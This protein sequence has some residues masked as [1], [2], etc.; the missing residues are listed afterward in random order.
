M[1]Q[2]YFNLVRKGFQPS[3]LDARDYITE[4]GKS[5]DFAYISRPFTEIADEDITI[6]D[7]DLKEYLRKNRET[8]RQDASRT[9]QYVVFEVEPSESDVESAR[10]WSSQTKVE[11]G[12]V[13]GDEIPRYVNG[14]SD[15]PYDARYYTGD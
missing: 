6:T 12:R 15:E 4:T 5:T 2:K 3:S 8:Y 1:N 11:F 7:A 13:T 14:T 9:F 10:Y